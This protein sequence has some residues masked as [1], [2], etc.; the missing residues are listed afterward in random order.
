MRTWRGNDAP[1]GPCSKGVIEIENAE[2]RATSKNAAEALVSI[3]RFDG[4]SQ[5]VYAGFDG[6]IEST[7]LA[8]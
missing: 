1:G 7:L 5:T 4:S 8:G 2:G 6:Q 3:N